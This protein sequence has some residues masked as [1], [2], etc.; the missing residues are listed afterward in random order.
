MTD[1]IH[2]SKCESCGAM[3][4]SFDTVNISSETKIKVLCS[5]CY[6]D[7]VS[8]YLGLDFQH[9]DFDPI[10]LNDLDGIPHTFEFRTHIFGSEVSIEALE[11]R[12]G[13]PKGYEFAVFGDAEED[14]LQLFRALFEKM[15]RGL[16]RKHI[17]E[18]EFT[19]Y[20]ITDGDTVRGRITWDDEEEG[21]VPCLIIDGKEVSWEEF[22]RILMGYEGFQF[23]L[24][25][26]ERYDER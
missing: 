19:E 1:N 7:S 13:Q 3:V 10:T 14:M 4:R 6:N 21:R 18:S 20:Q 24:E 25:I 11:I 2:K 17:E 22:G 23:K 9:V 12:D 15:K 5:K 26:F 8:Q 16:G